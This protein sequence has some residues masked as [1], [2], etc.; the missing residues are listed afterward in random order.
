MGNIVFKITS[1]REG[2]IWVCTGSGLSIINKKSGEVFNFDLSNGFGADG[3]DDLV[4]N[5]DVE[6]SVGGAEGV[7]HGEFDL[8]GVAEEKSPVV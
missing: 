8:E 4:I 6:Q 5:D 7:A 3:V 2:E 1:M